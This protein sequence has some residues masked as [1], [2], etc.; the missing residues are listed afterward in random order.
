M[1]MRAAL[2]WL[3]LPVYVWQGTRLRMRIERLLPA[4]VPVSGVVGAE[5]KGDELRL[6]VIGDSTVASVGMETLEETFA[7]SIA[8]SV[9]LAHS[10]RVEWRSAGAN[11]ATSGELRDFIVPNIDRRDWTHIFISV[12]INDMKNFHLAAHF[13][14]NFGTL[15][16]ALR[17]RFPDTILIWT[18]IPNMRLCPA[19]PKRLADVLAARADVINAMGVRMCQERGAVH[20]TPVGDVDA[21]CFARDGFHPNGKGYRVWADHVAP[22]FKPDDAMAEHPGNA[23]AQVTRLPRRA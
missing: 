19:L 20:T 5:H 12:G 7:Y 3:M 9:A 1:F 16:Y 14:R 17:T 11:S 10:K 15:L 18:P 6:L 22:W 23:T 2:S 13:K 4:R 8:Q 21:S